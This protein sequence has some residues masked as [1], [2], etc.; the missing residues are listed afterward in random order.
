[1]DKRL[2]YKYPYLSLQYV[3]YSEDYDNR[4]INRS[5][6]ENSHKHLLYIYSRN[7]NYRISLKET[8]NCQ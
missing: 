6:Y 7:N 5:L 2:I 1:M 4:M 3:I 8:V